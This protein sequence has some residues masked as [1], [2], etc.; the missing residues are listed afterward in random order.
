MPVVALLLRKDG[1]VIVHREA[2]DEDNDVRKDIAANYD[3]EIKEST[4]NA[5]ERNGNEGMMRMMGGGMGGG[6]R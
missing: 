5:K 6:M 1:S 3:H 2:D 4:R